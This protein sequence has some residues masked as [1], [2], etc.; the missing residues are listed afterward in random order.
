MPPVDETAANSALHPWLIA[1]AEMVERET[2]PT[3]LTYVPEIALRLAVEIAPLWQK[4]ERD[5]K[6]TLGP[7]YWAVAWAGGLAL[8]RHVLDHPELVK[9][10]RVLDFA[11]GSA[12]AGIAAAKAG[13]AHVVANDIDPLATVATSFN[14][15]LNAV[16]IAPNVADLMA[17]D[18]G[19][20]PA[21]YD[22]VLVGDVFYAPELAAHALAFLDGCRAGGCD[23]LI[24]DPGRIDLPLDHLVKLSSH[25]VPVTRDA[26]FAG[27]SSVNPAD[28]DLRAANVWRLVG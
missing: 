26:Q 9:G 6:L 4:V 27:A 5:L 21:D 15:D 7:P 3:R 12:L 24:G 25:T 22:V 23:V 13:A 8:A 14:A 10:R 19:F 16:A 28:Q 11:A 18:S 17:A 1:L 20:D 2:Q